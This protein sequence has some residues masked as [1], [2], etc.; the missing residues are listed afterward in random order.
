MA[1]ICT[2]TPPAGAARESTA[3]ARG[4]FEPLEVSTLRWRSPASACCVRRA[5][6]A[7]ASLSCAW[8]SAC[9]VGMAFVTLAAAAATEAPIP[10]DVAGLNVSFLISPRFLLS[11]GRSCGRETGPVALSAKPRAGVLDSGDG[12][13][14][15][16][17]RLAPLA[18]A[19]V[20]A[21]P[22]GRKRTLIFF[23]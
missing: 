2:D 3:D 22:A 21:S 7:L 8:S 9:D 11:A 1:V 10:P 17:S 20:E 13:G 12:E 16:E 23:S 15:S 18:L 14:T 6:C 4:A 19:G 5:I